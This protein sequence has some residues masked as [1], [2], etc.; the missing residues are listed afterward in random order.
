MRAMV[1]KMQLY[2]HDK[3][4]HL[5]ISNITTQNADRSDIVASYEFE[6]IDYTTLHYLIRHNKTCPN[7]GSN[8][9]PM[10][11]GD[12]EYSFFFVNGVKT[13]LYGRPLTRCSNPK[14]KFHKREL[15]DAKKIC[16]FIE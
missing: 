10:V 11:S 13:K 7:C 8:F 6:L 1:Y 5:F 2:R 14:C 9:S 15:M 16:G 12:E 4:Q 3:V